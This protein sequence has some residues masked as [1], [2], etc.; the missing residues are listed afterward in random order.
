MLNLL[1]KTKPWMVASLLVATSVFG[2]DNGNPPPR[3]CPPQQPC[4]KP[5]PK[6]DCCPTPKC[7]PPPCPQPCPPTQVCPPCP[8]ACCPPWPVPVLNAAYNYPARTVVR[9]PWD[10]W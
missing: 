10:I 4:A 8:V 1:K 3:S 6:P 5:C 9:C 2:Q 7:C